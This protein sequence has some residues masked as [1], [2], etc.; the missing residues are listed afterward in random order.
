[1][2]ETKERSCFRIVPREDELVEVRFDHPEREWNVLDERALE[3]LEGVLDRLEGEEERVR[4]VLFT[5][6]KENG[7]CVGADV[8]RMATCWDEQW[9]SA[10]ARR[11]QRLFAR[12]ERL[13][14][15]VVAAVDGPC[16][17]GGLELALACDRIVASDRDETRLGLPET[18][19]GIVPGFGGTQR[20]P[21]RVGLPAALDLVLSGRRVSGRIALSLGLVDDVVDRLVLLR[22]AVWWSSRTRHRGLPR[23]RPRT[24]IGRIGSAPGVRRLV[25]ER[26]RREVRRKARGLYPALPAAIDLL[27][28]GLTDRSGA[29]FEE[30]ARWVGRLLTE[31]STHHLIDLFLDTRRLSERGRRAGRE[32]RLERI[33][34]I[35]GGVMGSGI[36]AEAARRGLE[37][38]LREV[39]PR[40][41]EGAL[42][43]IARILDRRTHERKRR[44]AWDR[45]WPTCDWRGFGRLD[46]VI[47]AVV[48][49]LDVKREVFSRLE[50]S[51]PPGAALFTN[52]S[53]LPLEEIAERM[54]RPERLCG[55]HFFNPVE[56]MPLVEV[57]R[58]ERTAE[59]TLDKAHAL[60]VALGKTPVEVADG[61]GFLVNRVLARYFAEALFLLEEGFSPDEIDE[62]MLDYGFPMGPV[63]VLDVVG[64]DVAEAAARRLE[65]HM[66]ERL[67]RPRL[68]ARL[69]ERGILGRK[70]GEGLR[71][72]GRSRGPLSAAARAELR[73]LGVSA[74]RSAPGVGMC[75]RLLGPLLDEA[76]R[77]FDEGVAR[78][79]GDVDTAL[80]LG[81]GFPPVRRGPLTEIDAIGCATLLER[82][83]RLVREF[84]P[85]FTPGEGLVQRAKSG[86]S[87][88]EPLCEEDGR[89]PLA[90]R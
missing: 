37:V 64:L 59:E 39:G 54:E 60:A 46:A 80:V 65:A 62:T 70:S 33:G 16:L 85:R 4:G 20:L 55:L 57:V 23:K 38:R 82:L 35:G 81:A 48:E 84:G 72:G 9:A 58:G 34:V 1:M 79:A 27:E 10:M 11:G 13:P 63:A 53:S 25:A 87:A 83:H 3:D 88:R 66:G 73:A 26:A 86:S 43:S 67:G 44:D 61:P 24:W 51:T 5:T 41:L 22:A 28:R 30:E 47:E 8:S 17:G 32:G 78:E 77:A 14:V 36:A 42:S 19:L 15:P 76:L 49:R 69:V 18:R 2:S 29:G 12:I 56:R 75:D 71:R 7:F 90:T 52:T 21:R 50:R 40:P 89:E 45:I 31:Q 6:G 74:R 68:A